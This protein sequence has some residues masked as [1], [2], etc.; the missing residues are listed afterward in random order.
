[1]MKILSLLL[2]IGPLLVRG[3]EPNIKILSPLSDDLWTGKTEIRIAVSN[4]PPER[5]Q[6]VGVYLDGKMI[7]E[8]SSPPYLM[9]H[10]FGM[11]MGKRTLKVIAQGTGGLILQDEINSVRLDDVQKIKVTRVFIP[12]TV[13]DGSGNYVIDLKK[14][15]FEI[16]EDGKEQ[17]ILDLSLS[18]RS[19]VRLIMLIDVSSSMRNNMPMVK[20]AAHI[21]LSRILLFR[22]NQA[23]VVFF[24]KEIFQD[25]ESFSNDLTELFNSIDTVLPFGSTALYDAIHH[26]IRAFKPVSGRSILVVLSDGKDNSS[27]IDPFTLI[28]KA[29]RTNAMIYIVGKTQV[30]SEDIEYRAIL[31]QLSEASGGLS[32]YIDKIDEVTRIYKTIEEDIHSSYVLQISSP[33]R[34]KP[35]F[36]SVSVT[37]KN[38]RGLKVRTIKGYYN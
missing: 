29:E 37:L 15:D 5:I 22:K 24:N 12:V 2:L 27:Y 26:C 13:T 38:K 33:E 1:M 23:M 14:E 8:F 11:G 28:K 20:K 36:R 19:L 7:G 3:Q 34:K 35:E 4:V 25:I 21:L 16:R 9:S 10:D 17:A 18:E 32:F 6:N 30:V 31:D